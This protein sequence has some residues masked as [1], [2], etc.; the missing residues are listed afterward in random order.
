[1]EIAQNPADMLIV[2]KQIKRNKEFEH[3]QLEALTNFAGRARPNE[4]YPTFKI[5]MLLKL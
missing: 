1:M 3:K 2:S 4:Q 5:D